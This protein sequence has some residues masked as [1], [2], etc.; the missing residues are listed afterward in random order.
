MT[1]LTLAAA[2]R[3]YTSEQ[4]S[5]LDSEPHSWYVREATFQALRILKREKAQLCCANFWQVLIS[6][7]EICLEEFGLKGAAA[8]CFIRSQ[9]V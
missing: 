5:G 2:Q 6:A 3:L 7:S 4:T 1:H 9:N 8:V